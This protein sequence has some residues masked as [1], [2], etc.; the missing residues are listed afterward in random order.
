[1]SWTS[2]WRAP[3]AQIEYG[4]ARAELHRPVQKRIEPL[5]K[6]RVLRDGFLLGADAG[7]IPAR[8]A[9]PG[10]IVRLPESMARGFVQMGWGEL[11]D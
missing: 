10:E 5:L 7:V 8:E 6:L 1:M 2:Q 4:D 3:P 9:V 11:L